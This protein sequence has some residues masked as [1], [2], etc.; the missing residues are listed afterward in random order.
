MAT[1]KISVSMQKN[2][3]HICALVFLIG[4]FSIIKI[5]ANNNFENI[6]T[7]ENIV[8][9]TIE[10]KEEDTISF[11]ISANAPTEIKNNSQDSISISEKQIQQSHS[12]S[13]AEVLRKNANLSIKQYGAY[14]S[15]FSVYLRN[16]AGST[17]AI[18]V[19]GTS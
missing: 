13:L 9:N 19:D 15:A 4:F 16:F 17:V 18:L 5:Y 10:E 1:L 14:G 7:V 8:N 11:S 2:N 12:S 3:F 6:D